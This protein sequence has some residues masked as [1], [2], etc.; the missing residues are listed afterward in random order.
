MTAQTPIFL[1]SLRG[2]GEEGSVLVSGSTENL[3]WPVDWG[4]HVISLSCPVYTPCPDVSVFPC[5]MLVGGSRWTVPG[6]LYRTCT[7]LAENVNN[8]YSIH[9]L[10]YDGEKVAGLE[11]SLDE[12]TQSCTDHCHPFKNI[13]PIIIYLIVRGREMTS[14]SQL[15]CCAH[16]LLQLSYQSLLLGGENVKGKP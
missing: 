15:S 9:Y 16:C 8:I 14:L 10:R 12:C 7:S 2:P 13:T 11:L 5:E 4:S 1:S 6:T 3:N